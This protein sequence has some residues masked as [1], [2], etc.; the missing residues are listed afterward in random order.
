[1]HYVTRKSNNMWLK[2]SYKWLEW[3]K[4]DQEKDEKIKIVIV[5]FIQVIRNK[6]KYMKVQPKEKIGNRGFF[7]QFD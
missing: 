7:F 3:K 4:C 2:H 5:T 6:S 1:M